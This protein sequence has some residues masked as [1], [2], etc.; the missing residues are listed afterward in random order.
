MVEESGFYFRQKQRI[1]LFHRVH[2]CFGAN[3]TFCALVTGAYSLGDKAAG[4]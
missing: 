4:A 1:S 2:T 3:L